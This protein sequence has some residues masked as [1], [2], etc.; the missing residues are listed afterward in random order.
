MALNYK[1]TIVQ[2]QRTVG[3]SYSP[4]QEKPVAVEPVPPIHESTIN[5]QWIEFNESWYEEKNLLEIT[6]ADTGTNPPLCGFS[7]QLGER[8]EQHRL[9]STTF[10]T[11]LKSNEYDVN[12]FSTGWSSR[13]MAADNLIPQ[14]QPPPLS[15]VTFTL[16]LVTITS[17]KPIQHR[18]FEI[19]NFSN[20]V[21]KVFIN[22]SYRRSFTDGCVSNDGRDFSM[23]TSQTSLYWPQFHLVS[24]SSKKKKKK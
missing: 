19:Y 9:L 3:V 7:D 15:I 13:P 1:N 20:R 14:L 6:T 2:F 21:P 16:R 11:T 12:V 8:R 5:K 10:P 4:P 22:K 17:Q 23:I 18:F 24:R